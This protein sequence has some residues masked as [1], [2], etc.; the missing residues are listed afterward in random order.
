MPTRLTCPGCRAVLAVPDDV[1]GKVIRCPK[2]HAV[3]SGVVQTTPPRPEAG[4]VPSP[5]PPTPAAEPLE[6]FPTDEPPRSPPR[7][8]RITAEP[9][10]GAPV[11]LIIAGIVGLVL[12]LLCGGAG[13][14]GLI[15]YQR[16]TQAVALARAEEAQVA[17]VQA[18]QEA[19]QQAQGMPNDW[20][21]EGP[22][23]GMMGGMGGMAEG[24]KKDPPPIQLPPLPPAVEIKPASVQGETVYNLPDTV[25][26]VAVGGGGRF[27][28]LSFPKLHKLGVF[29]TNEAKITW[30]VPAAEEGVLFAAGMTKL[31]VYAP[32]ANIL[33][34][35]DL[36]THEREKVGKL[37]FP[38][39]RISAFCMGSASAGPLLACAVGD[40]GR[41]GTQLFDINSFEALPIGEEGT[42]PGGTLSGGPYWASADG[43]TLGHSGS[44]GMPN[45]VAAVSIQSGRAKGFYEHWGSWFVQ[46]G[47]DGKYIYA[48]GCGVFTDRVKPTTDAVFSPAHGQGNCEHMYLP[49]HHGPYYVHLHLKTGLLG[50]HGLPH[51]KE[52]P[53]HGLTVYMLGLRQP[54]AQLRD[55]GLV[56]YDTM[57][58][59]QGIGIERSVHLIPRAKLLVIL[60]GSRDKLL[61]HPMDL[62]KAL[63]DSGAHYLLVTSQPPAE[64]TAGERLTYE[65][66]AKSKAGGVTFKLESGPPGMTVTPDGKLTWT[67]PADLK[68]KQ[69]DVIVSL[70]DKDGQ[71]RFHT[72]T[73]TIR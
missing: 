26:G 47:P 65:M 38:A 30:Y 62:E 46:P 31:M 60:P 72:F 29:D 15:A 64:A 17:R 51:N 35:W 57:N 42:H 18:A 36:L 12:F 61:L 2:C 73:L 50:P 45:G 39:G 3:V 21:A 56:T 13:V 6:V 9:R 23:G 41:G 4:I 37:S 49:A 69:V 5:L 48:G 63:E 54:L 10:K 27:L 52:D 71:E 24:P 14:V 1:A 16:F 32:A 59:L 7:P 55:G 20:R 19:Q 67:V 40:F 70:R 44:L 66:A 58:A 22:G 33:Q 53:N 34:R 43:R 8:P 28:V 11:G 25:G 68:E